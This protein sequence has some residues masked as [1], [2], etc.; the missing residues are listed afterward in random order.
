MWKIAEVSTEQIKSA[1]MDGVW[2]NA[3]GE[4]DER[5]IGDTKVFYGNGRVH[6]ST[7]MK[8]AFARYGIV[9]KSAELSRNGH[10]FLRTVKTASTAVVAGA[11]V[12]INFRIV[13]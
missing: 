11:S 2:L 13:Y 6:S 3:D 5:F 10:P 8:N 9:F 4:F 1:F 7:V 12:G